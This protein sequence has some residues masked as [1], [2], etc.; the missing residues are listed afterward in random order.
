MSSTRCR[1]HHQRQVDTEGD[2][3]IQCTGSQ[4]GREYEVEDAS[5]V[6]DIADVRRGATLR[7]ARSRCSIRSV[8]HAVALAEDLGDRAS[9]SH[10]TTSPET[11]YREPVI[12]PRRTFVW[13]SEVSPSN[14]ER[15][16]ARFAQ[17]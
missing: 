12:W 7:A 8:G 16:C 2:V 11:S 5:M 15:S 3:A 6:V 10:R 9:S 13:R 1:D 17:A 14:D 4:P